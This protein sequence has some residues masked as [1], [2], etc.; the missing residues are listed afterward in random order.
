VID[1][2]FNDAQSLS[3]AIIGVDVVY[4]NDM[5]D[6]KGVATIAECMKEKNIKRIIVASILSIYNEVPG[7]FGKWNERMVGIGHIK[8]HARNIELVEV[9]EFDYTILRLTWLYNQNGNRNYMLTQK[10]EVFRGAQV[11]RQAV[12][13]LIVDIIEEPT[14]KFI[15][16]SI[17]VS[18]PNTE[19]DKPSF[20]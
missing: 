20:Y 17:G 19:W 1:G 6:A 2:D 4:V 11:T 5:N 9:P 16:T 15:K 3:L 8:A 12:S 10:G 13:Q 18:E 7:P 14:D